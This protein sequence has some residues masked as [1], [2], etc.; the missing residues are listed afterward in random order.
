MTPVASGLGPPRRGPAERLLR[1]VLVV[2]LIAV[3]T[4][5]A[6]HLFLTHPWA[7]DLVI[8]LR[9]AER[10]VAG[11]QPYLAESFLRG[12]ATTCPS[13]TRRSSCRSWPSSPPF[14]SGW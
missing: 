3:I 4:V 7:V 14:P 2:A 8:P 11:G 1:P 6:V 9:A 13:S 10:W 5:D 12:P